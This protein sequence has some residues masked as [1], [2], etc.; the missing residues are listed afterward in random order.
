[1]D[2]YL[3]IQTKIDNSKVDPQLAL[4]KNKLKNTQQE[5]AILE[6][7]TLATGYDKKKVEQDTVKLKAQEAKLTEQIAKSEQKS[8]E[9]RDY[10]KGVE[11]GIKSLKRFALSLFTVGSVYAMISKASNA[12]LSQDTDLAQKLQNVWVGLGSFLAPLIEYLSDVLLKGLG[13]L[14]EFIKALTGI[15]YIAR[16]NAKAIEKQADAQKKL[17]QLYSFDEMNVQQSNNTS[18]GGAS[19]GIIEIPELDTKIVDKLK[20]LAFWLKENWDWVSKVGLALIGVFGAV[21]IGKLLSG[22]GLLIGSK[23]VG[24]GLAGLLPLLTLVAGIWTISLYIDGYNKVKDSLKELNDMLDKNIEMEKGLKKQ[25][26]EVTKSYMGL[27]ESGEITAEQMDT[28]TWYLDSTSD[29]IYKQYS[30]LQK[31]KTWW[32]EF[33]GSNKKINEEQRILAERLGIVTDNYGKLFEQGKLNDTQAKDYKDS[34]EKQIV[35]MEGLGNN[36]DELRTKYEL[37]TGKQFVIKVGAEVTGAMNNVQALINKIKNLPPSIE[38]ATS[39]GAFG[40]GSGGGTRNAVGGIG[41]IVNNPGRG[42]SMGNNIVGEAGQEG[43]IPLTDPNAM[44]QLGESIGKWINVQITNVNKMDNKIISRQTKMLNSRD[45][46][47]TNGGM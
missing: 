4:L 14:N 16:A 24:T 32:G 28:L 2:G 5:L 25:T 19:S 47:A 45:S 37:L 21:A 15:D 38:I 35:I 6:K 46:F 8:V 40:G 31:S 17:N 3:R 26:D 13:Y 44:A 41:S 42:I 30:E 12:Y 9:K 23:A 39:F 1:M 7:T 11:K 33:T 27:V 29:S 18:T 34:L 22:I 10:S 36:T 20:E 43:I